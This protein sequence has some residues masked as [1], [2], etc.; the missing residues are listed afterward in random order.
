MIDGRI[1]S[2]SKYSLPKTCS[3]VDAKQDCT[4]GYFDLVDVREVKLDTKYDSVLDQLLM[5]FFEQTHQ[6]IDNPNETSEQNLFAFTNKSDKEFFNLDGYSFSEDKLAEFWENTDTFNRFFSLMHIE[7]LSETDI[8]GVIN[9]LNFIFNDSSPD[10]YNAVFYFSFDY[11][12]LIICAKNMS[13]TN[14]TEK[15]FEVN[16]SQSKQ[17]PVKNFSFCIKDS[18]SLITFNKMF[19]ENVFKIIKSSVGLKYN[20]LVNLVKEEME[21]NAYA[22]EEENLN[23]VYNI[24]VQ[25]FDIFNSFYKELCDIGMDFQKFAMLGRHDVT[26][27]KSDADIVWFIIL[28]Y[29]IDKYTTCTEDNKYNK[30]EVL[31]NCESFVR[32]NINLSFDHESTSPINK[33]HFC[34]GVNRHEVAKN[35]LDC[36]IRQIASPNSSPISLVQKNSLRSLY[37]SIESTLKNGFADDFV[38]C[39]YEPFIALLDYLN[40]KNRDN[41]IGNAKEFDNVINRFFEI[42]SSLVNSTMHSDRQFIQTPS[43]NPV[44]FDVPPKLMAFYTAQINKIKQISGCDDENYYSFIFK[45][46]LN[47]NITIFPYSYNQAPPTDR[48]LAV[49]INEESLYHPTKVLKVLCHEA[50][51]FVGSN[52]RCRDMR[53]VC[54]V[55]SILF[56]SFKII[57]SYLDK[58]IKGDTTLYASISRV[59]SDIF[60][61]IE[62]DIQYK[63]HAGYSENINYLIQHVF[64]LIS[65]NEEI[66]KI[67]TDFFVDK[68]RGSNVLALKNHFKRAVLVLDE[69]VPF[70]NELEMCSN[71]PIAQDFYKSYKT[72]LNAYKESYADIQMILLLDLSLSDYIRNLVLFE[73]MDYEHFINDVAYYKIFPVVYTLVILGIRDFPTDVNVGMEESVD[74]NKI[75]QQIREYIVLQNKHTPIKMDTGMMYSKVVDFLDIEQNIF[76]KSVGDP[77]NKKDPYVTYSIVQYLVEVVK[78]TKESF[79]NKNIENDRAD[80]SA[81]TKSVFHFED[82]VK[83]F[84][85]IQKTNEKYLNSIINQSNNYGE[86]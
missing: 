74:F 58:D 77:K 76:D 20:E 35:S 67:L 40:K 68:Y 60:K 49:S 10:K 3:L 5:G 6:I 64:K 24:G 66:D 11:S 82:S 14:F 51:H 21:R 43:F 31:F 85:H 44:F 55:K 17:Y 25:N 71:L 15:L 12:D 54:W 65:V 33:C 30:D 37:R 56:C 27:N 46:S 2:F 57:L 78:K 34:A 28:L 80:L 18:F 59:I 84:S 16:Y 22:Y 7:C 29:Y 4:I 48:L 69:F 41:K 72:L 13:V 36:R 19:M 8:Y 45:P 52:K 86:I 38:I 42:V 32:S 1:F 53:K 63:N 81:L 23:I 50:S 9:W 61:V 26:I 70:N 83:M 39:L 47:R 75:I 79:L 62:K 73:K